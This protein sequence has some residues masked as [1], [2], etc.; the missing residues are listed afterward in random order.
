[1]SNWFS[2]KHILIDHLPW[3]H[4][5]IIFFF[6]TVWKMLSAKAYYDWTKKKSK[7]KSLIYI[8]L[9][10]LTRFHRA[11]TCLHLQCFD[12]SLFLQM[13]ERKPTWNCPVCDKAA[14]YETLVIDGYVSIDD[15]RFC[16]SNERK[17]LMNWILCCVFLNLFL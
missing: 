7:I 3:Q 11:S 8:P 4:Q 5:T 9:F 16:F 14:L 1:M 10:Q 13:N 2:P 17:I 12:A 6:Y 15:T